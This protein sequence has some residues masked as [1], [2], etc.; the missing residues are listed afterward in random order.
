MASIIK[1]DTIKDTS[2]NTLLTSSSGNVSISNDLVV[3]TNTLYVDSSNNRIGIGNTD[4]SV[5]LHLSNSAP[6]IRLE[7]TNTS[8]YSDISADSSSGSLFIKADAGNTVANTVLGFFVDNTEAMRIDGGK[9]VG[10]AMSTVGTVR[11]AVASDTA[12]IMIGRDS[13]GTTDKFRIEADGDVRNTNNSYG[14]I[15]DI[16]LKQDITNASSQWEDIK[17]LQVKNYRLIKEVEENADAPRHIGVIAQELEESNMAGLV[18]ESPKQNPDGTY[19]ENETE[20]NVKYSVLYMKAVKA[21]Q[22]AMA[23]IESLETENTSIKARLEALE[24][25]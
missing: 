8:A 16:N 12:F 1:V 5:P 20:K 10:I 25:A 11:F 14:A 7:D 4:P 6:I 24:N 9:R 15:S 2:D 18:K 22:E 19:S 17:A 23:R 3:D 13:S 21:L